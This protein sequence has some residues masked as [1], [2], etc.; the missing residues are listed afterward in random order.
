[1]ANLDD[2]S[3]TAYGMLHEAHRRL[4]RAFSRSIE[5]S[6]G[7]PGPEFEV[8]LRVGRSPD[9]H[10]RMTDLAAQLGLTSGGTTRLVDRVEHRGLVARMACP[11]DRRVQW[12]AL[13]PEGRHLLD[14]A[15]E[16]HL[17]DLDREFASRLT[18]SEMRTLVRL[19]D[20]V[21]AP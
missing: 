5:A 9:Q 1:M 12:V 20:K 3:I 18:D 11:S 19:L 13:T 21:R 2:E 15:V 4:E 8:L 7:I 10:L 6:L 16:M 14:E 17:D